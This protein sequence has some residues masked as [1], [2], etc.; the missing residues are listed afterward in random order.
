MPPAAPCPVPGGRPTCRAPAP[1][2]AV[3]DMQAAGDAIAAF[4]LALLLCCLAAAVGIGL[5]EMLS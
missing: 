1:L 3:R 2:C 5:T 4:L